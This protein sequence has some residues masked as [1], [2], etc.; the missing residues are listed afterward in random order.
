MVEFRGSDAVLKAGRLHLP[1]VSG[2]QMKIVE[3]ELIEINAVIQVL[4]QVELYKIASI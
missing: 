1:R 3:K 4:P 2:L